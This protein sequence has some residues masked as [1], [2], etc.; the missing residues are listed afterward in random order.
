M[1]TMRAFREAFNLSADW[2]DLPLGAAL[3][4]AS[5]Y[6]GG[7]LIAAQSTATTQPVVTHIK[8]PF[9]QLSYKRLTELIRSLGPES[10]EA[11][12]DMDTM[13]DLLATKWERVAAEKKRRRA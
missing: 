12:K 13:L 11:V 10:N 7:P 8:W 5:A 9:R 3:P 6:G 1:D 4:S 2:F